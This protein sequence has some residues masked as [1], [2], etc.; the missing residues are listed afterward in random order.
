MGQQCLDLLWDSFEATGRPASQGVRAL[1]SGQRRLPTR[2]DDGARWLLFQ[3]AHR[4]GMGLREGE[5]LRGQLCWLQ[6]PGSCAHA[7]A[8]D[9]GF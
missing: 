8:H 2:Q 6:P 5:R 7:G 4:L 9:Q 3:A 1:I